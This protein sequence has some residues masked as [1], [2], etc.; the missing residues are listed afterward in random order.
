MHLKMSSSSSSDECIPDN[1]SQIVKDLTKTLIQ[2]EATGNA[3]KRG[4]PKGMKS[5]LEAI[6]KQYQAIQEALEKISDRFN[7]FDRKMTALTTEL[8][9]V[10]SENSLLREENDALHFRVSTLET[11]LDEME[12]K[13][14]SDTVMMDIKPN[15]LIQSITPYENVCHL[16]ETELGMPRTLRSELNVRTLGSQNKIPIRTSTSTIAASLLKHSRGR[17]SRKF[18]INEFLTKKRSKL[19]YEA[20]KF[21]KDHPN[22]FHSVFVSDGKILFRRST[23]SR[24][25]TLKE[26]A[27]LYNTR[28]NLAPV[29]GMTRRTRSLDCLPR[30]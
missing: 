18:Y 16:L 2:S 21:K 27:Q 28:S 20:R 29:P 15:A 6:S 23:E 7:S 19:F 17:K 8:A 5:Q 22:A 1:S 10:S 11:A 14:L 9:D 13:Q 3:K 4:R 26:L 24:T 30:Y 25:E 12:Q